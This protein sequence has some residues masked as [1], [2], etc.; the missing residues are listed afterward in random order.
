MN[1]S[2]VLYAAREAATA[3]DAD[4][5]SSSN[6]LELHHFQN[7]PHTTFQLWLIDSRRFLVESFNSIE[8]LVFNVLDSHKRRAIEMIPRCLRKH[9]SLMAFVLWAP[10]VSIYGNDLLMGRNLFKREFCFY[11]PTLPQ[12][13]V[14]S[15]SSGRNEIPRMPIWFHYSIFISSFL[16]LKRR[17]GLIV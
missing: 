17:A 9:F 10:A 1:I 7:F 4:E 5:G 14:S 11:L 2:A 12:K 3:I 6:N 8:P 15:I 13:I 16:L